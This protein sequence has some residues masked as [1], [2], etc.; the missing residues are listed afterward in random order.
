MTPNEAVLKIRRQFNDLT[1]LQIEDYKFGF[2]QYKPDDISELIEHFSNMYEYQNP[3]KWAYFFKAALKLGIVQLQK[4][5]PGWYKCNSCKTEYSLEGKRCPKCGSSKA[6]I[7]TGENKPTNLVSMKEDCSFC[8]EF[9]KITNKENLRNIYGN[10]CEEHGI[11]QTPNSPCGA[12]KCSECCSQL[13]SYNLDPRGTVEKHRTGELK[14]DWLYP[15]PPLDKTL[16]Q[17][18]KNIANNKRYVK[19]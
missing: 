14:Q 9:Y 2:E 7:K 1:E 19:K 11:K 3:P 6:T 15:C 13:I 17:I 16:S 8:K 12:C 18:V 4:S 5:K 10:D